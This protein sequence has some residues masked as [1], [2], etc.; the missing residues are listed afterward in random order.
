MFK[1][2][3][4]KVKLLTGFLIGAML[5]LLTGLL[6]INFT[7]IVGNQGIEIGVK[8]APLA[9][10]AMEVKLTATTA[11]LWFEEILGGDTTEDVQEVFDLLDESLWFCN[12]MLLGGTN[13][14]G[15]FYAVK[16]L[17]IIKE[18]KILSQKIESFIELT[19]NRYDARN[20]GA[21]TGSNL[22]EK[23]D[24]E[25]EELMILAD[26]VEE[27]IHDYMDAGE[28][29]L[30]EAK[31]QA[32]FIM[33]IISLIGFGVAIF[34][35]IFISSLILKP[36]S[37][38]I[39]IT[40][41]I[42]SGDLRKR[43]GVDQKDEIGQLASS[44]NLMTDSM[45]RIIT[46]ITNNTETLSTSGTELTTI[47]KEMDKESTSSVTKSNTVASASEEMSINMDNITNSMKITTENI[48][49]VATGTEE[50][51]SSINEIAQNASKST[52]IT[53]NA[54]E[55]AK[56]A[57]IQVKELGNAAKEIVKVTDTIT[58]ISNQTNL[59]AL[60]ATIEAARAGDAGKGFA[61][62]ANEIKEL[63]KQTADATEEIAGKLNDV[64]QSSENTSDVIKVITGI[65]E[66]INGVVGTIAAAVE[67]QNA[68]TSENAGKINEVSNSIMEINENVSHGRIAT[69]QIAEEIIDVNSSANEMSN[70]ASQVLNS[71]DE[72]NKMVV[73]LKGI[74]GKFNV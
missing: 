29:K 57:S 70:I 53:N 37:K 54:V 36:L 74:V 60:N 68:T 62:V 34:L 43:V 10:C 69:K 58:E 19:Q 30:A 13:D 56:K 15:T 21:D 48:N 3:S 39:N 42:A 35:T 27:M 23:F 73:K 51:S 9:D 24:S 66:E 59:L 18:I 49:T 32:V 4:V 46:D 14:E 7:N 17:Q 2:V 47:A 41:Q 64:Q 63:A 20:E 11:H 22:D 16:N 31:K 26:V 40:K 1:N 44:I 12:A 65:I 52:E 28:N 72:L 38:C 25:F 71:S 45:Q 5:I 33:T 6:G 55:Q 8:L 61:I 67:E 50:M